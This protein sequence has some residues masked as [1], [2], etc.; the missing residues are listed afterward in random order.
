M[1]LNDLHQEIEAADMASYGSIVNTF[2]ELEPEYVKLYSKEKGS[3]VWCI[4]PVS[5]YNKDLF[6]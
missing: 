1:L 2:E 5:L 6:D 4:G 3:R